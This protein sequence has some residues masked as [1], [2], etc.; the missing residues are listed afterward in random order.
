MEQTDQQL[1]A[2]F[3]AG[4]DASFELLVHKN[5]KPV[6]NFLFRLTGGD[7]A[8]TDDLTQETWLKAWK[9]IQKFDREKNF[10]TWLFSIAKN[11]ARDAWKKK[12]TLPFALFENSAGY[13]KLD[14]MAE[15]KLLP[16]EILTQVESAKELEE[17]L[18]KLSKKHELVLLLRYRDDLSLAE[19][20]NTLDL[21]YNTIKSQHKRALN[22]LKKQFLHP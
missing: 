16:D 21:P 2:D 13:N 6:Y 11:S 4:D 20:A 22:E 5:L 14:E 7:K 18:K 9:N 12:K 17:K 19:I 10:K 1:I 15:D 3:L 8:L